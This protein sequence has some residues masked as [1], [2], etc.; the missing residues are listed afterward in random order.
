MK[1]CLALVL[2]LTLALLALPS[3]ARAQCPTQPAAP[4]LNPKS[5]CFPISPDHNVTEAGQNKV[6]GYKLLIKKVSDGSTLATVD[7][8]KPTPVNGTITLGSPAVPWTPF[9]TL[10]LGVDYTTTTVAYGRG[11]ETPDGASV[12]FLKP[13]PPAPAG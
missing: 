4:V 8:G 1:N 9:T 13:S 2:P 12:S 6:D 11:L 7:I 5:V 10:P 3:F